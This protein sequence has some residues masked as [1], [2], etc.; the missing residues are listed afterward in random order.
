MSLFRRRRKPDSHDRFHLE[1]DFR[2]PE[3]AP[4]QYPVDME[5]L[6]ITGKSLEVLLEE[7]SRSQRPLLHLYMP[8]KEREE[9]REMLVSSLGRNS[10]SLLDLSPDRETEDFLR[11]YSL[12]RFGFEHKNYTYI[13]ETEVM[14]RLEG[15]D[16]LF[17]AFKPE[18][19][20]QE[21]RSHQRYK[22]WP[23]Y[24]AYFRD[25]SVLDISQRGLKVFTEQRLGSVEA[26]ENEALTLPSVHDSNT[27]ETYYSG[28]EIEVP[29]ATVTHERKHRGVY[30]Y[31]LDF[32]QTWSSE[33]TKALND[34]LLALRKCFFLGGC[35]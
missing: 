24:K 34:F 10:M 31:G 13:F 25:M 18:R 28:A 27:G 16:P 2:S 9:A 12:V 15:E 11:D 32:D 17:L 7:F 4:A 3:R 26:L 30:Y 35:E 1:E 5:G 8:S 20:Y 33:Q 23:D 14:A 21:R 6:E 22:L 29:R 19:I